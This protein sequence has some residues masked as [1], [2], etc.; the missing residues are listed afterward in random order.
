MNLHR[1][2]A[3]RGRPAARL[4]HAVGAS[5]LL[6]A[7]ILRLCCNRLEMY[8]LDW[9]GSGAQCCLASHSEGRGTRDLL[10]H[11]PH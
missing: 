8:P 9:F 1:S 3:G 11:L 7:E 2:A 5:R 10:L 4:I 6:S